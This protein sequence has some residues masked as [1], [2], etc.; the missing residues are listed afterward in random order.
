MT[1]TKKPKTELFTI[2][3]SGAVTM[4]LGA[5]L[6]IIGEFDIKNKLTQWGMGFA[7]VGLV[8]V[9]MTTISSIVDNYKKRRKNQQ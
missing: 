3:V 5:I 8:F 4:C 6:V 2:M 9:V 1:K 7:I